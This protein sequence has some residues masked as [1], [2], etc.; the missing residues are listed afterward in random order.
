MLTL[1]YR[2]VL[3][4][5]WIAWMVYWWISS[6]NVKPTQRRETMMSRLLHVIPLSVAALLVIPVRLP[7]SLLY[8]RLFP[9]AP[10]Q[11]WLACAVTA[12]G[13]LF[14]VWAR[15]H[16][17]R[18]W[19]ALVTIKEEQELITTGPYALV[20][21]PIYTG[22]LVAFIACAF[23]RGDVRGFAGACIAVVAL[24]RKLRLEER[25]MRE[26]FGERYADYAQRVPALVP[27]WR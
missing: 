11:F 5:M 15:T 8:H 12:A 27:F 23:A 4:A 2:F 10:W 17:G 26:R 19:S 16:L 18:N 13:L 21:H 24:W 1:A 22:L 25:W 20:R 9:W 14:T 3:P 6:S 7:G